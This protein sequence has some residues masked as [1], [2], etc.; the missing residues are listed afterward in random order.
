[1]HRR[2]IIVLAFCI[3]CPIL[4][5]GAGK[6]PT[7]AQFPEKTIIIGTHAIALEVLN[8][9]LLDIALQSATSP[10]EGPDGFILN[11]THIYFKSDIN[12]GVWY[13][14]TSST[15]ITQISTTVD[16]IVPNSVIDALWLTHYTDAKG[17]TIDLLSEEPVALTALFNPANPANMPEMSSLLAEYSQ[18]RQ[19]AEGEDGEED[20]TEEMQQ[21]YESLSSVFE[22]ITG[23][24]IEL[25]DEQ[26]GNI[27]AF[28]EAMQQQG[29]SMDKLAV[30]LECQQ[31]VQQQ[32]AALCY[33]TVIDRIN[34]EIKNLDKALLG[35]L[36]DAY[37]AALTP[38]YGAANTAA[39]EQAAPTEA[40]FGSAAEAIAAEAK[41]SFL[42]NARKPDFN[43]MEANVNTIQGVEQLLGNGFKPFGSLEDQ[44]NQLNVL[45]DIYSANQSAMMDV[46]AKGGGN[47]GYMQAMAGGEPSGVLKK[48]EDESV[49]QLRSLLEETLSVTE[50]LADNAQTPSERLDVYIASK[51]ATE[52]A[53][54]ELTGTGDLAARAL[55]VLQ[56]A[57][58]RMGSALNQAKLDMIPAYTKATEEVEALQKQANALNQTYLGAVEE[59]ADALRDQKKA[60]LDGVLAALGLSEAK[61]SAIEKGLVEGALGVESDGGTVVIQDETGLIASLDNAEQIPLVTPEITSPGE[62]RQKAVYTQEEVSQLNRQVQAMNSGQKVTMYLPPWKLVFEGMDIKLVSPV[63]VKQDIVYVPAKELA[64]QLGATYLYSKPN[65]GYVVKGNGVLIEFTPG[66][67][68]IHIND[69]KVMGLGGTFTHEG[70]M[71][72]PLKA[73]ELAFGWDERQE[74]DCTIVF[75]K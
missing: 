12:K 18:L 33:Q 17:V 34:Q 66:D 8:Q 43:A 26:I 6:R 52:A 49:A 58:S 42:E 5:F 40:A 23:E 47:D 41:V 16:N 9:Q 3:I 31:M 32:K 1:M 48:Y 61:K 28:L 60:E 57:D 62:E 72:V 35:D 70:Q 44:Q 2:I 54:V 67:D 4:V 71:Y 69:K 14:I 38:L 10:Y 56:E 36:I 24:D 46:A 53:I 25:L 29:A 22:E 21:K 30:A 45:Q 64:G 65:N 39:G 75:K 50:V 55:L 63:I 59:K 37:V 11:Q 13:D 51:A 7:A 73:F 27:Q 19:M 15:N 20:L 74:G 68:T